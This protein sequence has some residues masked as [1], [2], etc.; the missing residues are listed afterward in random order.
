LGRRPRSRSRT[1]GRFE[2]GSIWGDRTYLANR[3][4]LGRELDM[5]QGL[6]NL[7]PL[8]TISIHKSLISMGNFGTTVSFRTESTTPGWSCIDG[9]CPRR[10]ALR[11]RRNQ[12]RPTSVATVGTFSSTQSDPQAPCS[13]G[14]GRRAGRCSTAR[15]A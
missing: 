15:L 12:G 8:R 13:I 4:A 2:R 5:R 7:K 9:P 11:R 6:T 3:C 1:S 14:S 10:T